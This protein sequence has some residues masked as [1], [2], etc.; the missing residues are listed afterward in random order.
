MSVTVFLDSPMDGTETVEC[1]EAKLV[2]EVLL[3]EPTDS[4]RTQVIPMRNVAG[5]EG[6]DI[7]KTIEAVEYEG[8][9]MTE[10]VTRVE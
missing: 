10:L 9:R 7:E 8:G 1:E 5:V 3:T 2:G 4:D 6:D